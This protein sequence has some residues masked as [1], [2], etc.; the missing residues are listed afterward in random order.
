MYYLFF[1]TLVDTIVRDYVFK[2]ITFDANII[3]EI[4]ILTNKNKTQIKQSCN[5]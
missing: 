5:F 2:I 1:V 3:S 4:H